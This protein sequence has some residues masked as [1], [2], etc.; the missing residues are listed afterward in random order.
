MA[1]NFNAA[2]KTALIVAAVWGFIYGFNIV[3]QSAAMMAPA[4]DVGLSL[5]NAPDGVIV[6]AV[7][8]G[9]VAA[10]AGMKSGDVIVGVGGLQIHNLEDYLLR[11]GNLSPSEKLSFVVSRNGAMP[12][13]VVMGT[14]AAEI[15]AKEAAARSAPSP[16][17]V[18]QTTRL[19]ISLQDLQPG[20]RPEGAPAAPQVVSVESGSLAEAAGLREGDYIEAVDRV[21]V[22]SQL[23]V[24]TKVQGG[25]PARL[26]LSVWRAGERKNIEVVRDT[27]SK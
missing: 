25:M 15:E 4:R 23:D 1:F 7:T 17:G 26:L 22:S 19:G 2:G 10:K 5:A 6:G 11:V 13:R 3:S 16:I 14:D 24:A 27:E 20:Q 9:S 21:N 18:R 8:P 12:K